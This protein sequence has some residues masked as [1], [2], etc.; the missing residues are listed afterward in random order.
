MTATDFELMDNVYPAGNYMFK[1]N[2]KNARARCEM[3]SKL[4]LSLILVTNQSF[5]KRSVFMHKSCCILS[6]I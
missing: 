3:C 1:V 6:I 2:N 4:Y 5:C